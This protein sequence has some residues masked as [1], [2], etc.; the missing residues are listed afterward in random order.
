M[1]LSYSFCYNVPRYIDD[2]WYFFNPQTVIKQDST[3]S[4]LVKSNSSVNQQKINEENKRKLKSML[5]N[6]VHKFRHKSKR[7]KLD[8]VVMNDIIEQIN[9]IPSSTLASITSHKFYITIQKLIRDLLFDWYS[10]LKLNQDDTF[11]LRNCV[12]FLNRLVH[13][14]EDVTVL[15]SWLLDSSLINTISD[16]INDINQLLIKDEE[17]HNFKQ[18]IRLMD[19][20]S[21]YYQQLPLE[22]KNYDQL[23]RLFQA[24]MNCLISSN[25]DRIFRKLKP[26][27]KSMTIEEK[28]FL[29]Q[30]P[31]FLISYHN[32]SN[33]QSSQIKEQLLETMVPR[34]ASILDKHIKSINQWNSA[35]IRSVHYLL[36]TVIHAKGHYTPYANGQPLH[37][38][39]DEIVCI[40]NESTII[41]KIDE[42]SITSETILIDSAIKTLVE[43]VHEPDLLSYIKQLK[44]TSIFR[45]LLSLSYESIIYHIYILL[46]YTM[47]EDDIKSSEKESGRL[48]SDILD[49]LRKKIKLLSEKNENEEGVKRDIA[50][51]I[52]AVQGNTIY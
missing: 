41:K 14:V 47:S 51:L 39:I 29:I 22:F 7:T 50:L 52:E 1:N 43:F 40:I 12:L 17:K 6:Y 35:M 10:S 30:C 13:S 31:A 32:N 16:A 26:N 24:T 28:F 19:T 21:T 46:S 25:Y 38:L 45:S 48:L 11:L 5:D 15:T 37:W 27:A 33:S 42:N 20:F 3:Q 18:L 4:L 36:L 2:K 34:Y 23:N 49:S 44:I 9:K 8:V